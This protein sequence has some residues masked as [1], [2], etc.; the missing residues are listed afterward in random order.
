MDRQKKFKEESLPDKESHYSE[1]NSEH[2]T[3]EDHA[4]AQKVW[5]TFETK[6]LGE[7][8]DLYIHSDTSLLA[9]VFENVR[10]KCIEKYELDPA[11]LL[12]VPGLTQQTCLK[13]TGVE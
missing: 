4:H 12:F 3:D 1:L 9:D 6:N 10:D 2:I 13:M 11:H 8:H 7:Y 5:G